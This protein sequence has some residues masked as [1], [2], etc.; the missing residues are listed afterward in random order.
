M[1]LNGSFGTVRRQDE[2]HDSDLARRDMGREELFWGE[3]SGLH[4]TCPLG[5]STT[6]LSASTRASSRGPGRYQGQGR[7]PDVVG[8]VVVSVFVPVFVPMGLSSSWFSPSMSGSSSSQ[9]S[10]LSD[11]YSIKQ[12]HDLLDCDVELGFEELRPPENVAGSS[13][14]LHLEAS[15]WPVR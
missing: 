11:W 6:A 10:S 9:S 12:R 1:S 7:A 14:S 15:V 3:W 2:T 5:Q 13:Q 8:L 4:C